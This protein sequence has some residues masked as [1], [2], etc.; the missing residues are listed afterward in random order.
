L[1]FDPSVAVLVIPKWGLC[2]QARHCGTRGR[3]QTTPNFSIDRRNYPCNMIEIATK[4][5][6]FLLVTRRTS[7]ELLSSPAIRLTDKRHL[8]H[9]VLDGV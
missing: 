1:P 8:K 9:T 3:T 5:N 6:H 2:R 4:S 7:P